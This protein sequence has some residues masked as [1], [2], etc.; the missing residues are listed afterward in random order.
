MPS[1]PPSS[2]CSALV[3]LVPEAEEL[4]G[5]FRERYDPSA[6]AGMPAHITLLYPF[7]PPDEISEIVF[8]NLKQCAAL[9][10]RF[11]FSLATVRRFSEVVYL[12]PEPDEPFRRLTSALW[13]RFPETPPYGGQYPSIVPH[14]TIAQLTD[15]QRLDRI[16]IEFAQAARGKLPIHAKASE[17]TLMDK[18]RGRW[19]ARAVLT[20][21]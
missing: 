17:F 4:V 18:R 7:K 12:V 8:D 10:G 2:P 19:H 21:R 13:D 3:V 14:L 1:V 15:G 16:V 20:L 9:I 6:A 5:P 11:D